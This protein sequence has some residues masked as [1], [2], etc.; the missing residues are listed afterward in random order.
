M[1][2]DA[3]GAVPVPHLPW[4]SEIPKTQVNTSLAIGNLKS[5]QSYKRAPKVWQEESQPLKCSTI[6]DQT[7]YNTRHDIASKMFT[8]KCLIN[9]S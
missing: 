9:A 6:K 7:G 3:R 4:L 2:K 5:T 1:R 8:S